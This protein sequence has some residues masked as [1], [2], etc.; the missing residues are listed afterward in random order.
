MELQ[1]HVGEIMI[2]LIYQIIWNMFEMFS[3][4]FETIFGKVGKGIFYL[5]YYN[6][7]I[8]IILDIQ[9]DLF[10]NYTSPL[11]LFHGPNY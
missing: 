3:F 8:L 6:I 2:L 5:E 4:S 10:W 1:G 9:L 11:L 7:P